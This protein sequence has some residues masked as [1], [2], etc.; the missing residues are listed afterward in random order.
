MSNVACYPLLHV[1]VCFV[2]KEYGAKGRGDVQGPA[3]VSLDVDAGHTE[4]ARGDSIQGTSDVFGDCYR[5]EPR[6][7]FQKSVEDSSLTFHGHGLPNSRRSV[8][9]DH[10]PFA[11]AYHGP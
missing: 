11:F 9:E 6:G 7:R 10:T 4:L 1:N 3:Q 8:K 2:K 5:C